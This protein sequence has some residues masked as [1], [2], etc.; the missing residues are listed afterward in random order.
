[1]VSMPV[2]AIIFSTTFEKTLAEIPPLM[3]WMM[4]S[5]KGR[6]IVASIA[7]AQP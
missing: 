6:S 3:D 1:M 7:G 5:L 2:S 4:T